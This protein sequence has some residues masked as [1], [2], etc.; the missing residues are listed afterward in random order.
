M[1]TYN[2][3]ESVLASVPSSS[4][5]LNKA[6]RKGIRHST[7]DNGNKTTPSAILGGHGK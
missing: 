4:T 5:T 7:S 3:G 1:S 6:L 2:A